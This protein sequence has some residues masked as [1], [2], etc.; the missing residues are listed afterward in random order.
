MSD[1]RRGRPDGDGRTTTDVTGR[2]TGGSGGDDTAA[3]QIPDAETS[4]PALPFARPDSGPEGASSPPSSSGPSRG[5]GDDG[6]AR[7]S[8]PR[9]GP[10]SDARVARSGRRRAR[11][12]LTRVDP[13]SVLLIS[14]VL[15]L[16]VGVVLLVAVTVLYAMLD[17]LG[18]LSSVDALAQELD[19]VAEGQPLFGLSRVLGVA[20]VIAAVDVVLLTVLATLGAFLYNLCASLTGGVEVTLTERDQ[21]L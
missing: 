13:W 3:M 10:R 4:T 19:L 6:T 5:P 15:A 18:V 17:G 14:F 11:L 20:A 7:T 21:P 2:D 9:V 16:F 1:E 12:G 8:T